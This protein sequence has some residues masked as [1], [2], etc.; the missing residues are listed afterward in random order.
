MTARTV[1]CFLSLSAMLIAGCSAEWYTHDADREVYGIVA[2]KEADALGRVRTFNVRPRPDPVSVLES[3]RQEAAPAPAEEAAPDDAPPAPADA[4]AGADAA[5][6]GAK[7]DHLLKE[8]AADL[9]DI[10]PAELP[11]PVPEPAADAVHLTM[12]DALRV[13]VAASRTYQS[14]KEDVYLSALALTLQRYLFRPHPTFTGTVDSMSD[15]Q[16]GNG[17][18]RSWDPGAEVGVSQQLADGAVVAGSLGVAALK[19]LNKELGDTVDAALD[20]SLA[21]PLWRG[22]G[23]KIVQENLLQAER[24]TIYDIRSFARFEKTFAVSVASEYL[25]TLQS[26]DAVMNAWNNYLSL[27]QGRQQSEWLAQ[28]ERLAEYEVD[29]ARQSEFAAYNRWIV[30]REDYVNALDALKL[31]LGIPVSTEIALVPEE[32]DRLHEAGLRHTEQPLLDATA[33][34]LTNRLDL[35]N[36]LAAVDDARRKVVIAEDGLKGDVDLVASIGYAPRTADVQSARIAL[37]RG[38]YSIGFDIDLPVD[39]L[40]ERNALRET[41]ISEQAALR[42]LEEARDSVV[43]EVRQ[44]YRRLQQARESYG[45][46]KRSVALAERR[47]ESTRLLLQAGRADQRDVLEAEGDLLQARNA[48]TGA[49]VTH[50]IASLQFARDLGTLA[51]D[52]KGQIHG[53]ILTDNGR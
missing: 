9:E 49:L 32:L 18:V 38:D 7:A 43:L 5:E 36:T 35:A 51:V 40:T 19:Y 47:V 8:P 27:R 28:A 4:A 48:L 21:Q 20:F 15:F 14:R 30:E 44:A 6:A 34:A 53:W 1:A 17:R 24:N 16:D 13:A 2:E 33:T 23:R 25:Q 45:I 12:A 11:P 46:Q 10:I 52:E 42:A 41:Q 26:R 39:R 37:A 29:Q 22:A 3:A 31:T 50:T